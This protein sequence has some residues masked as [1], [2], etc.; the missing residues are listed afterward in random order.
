MKGII[1]CL[2]RLRPA[3]VCLQEVTPRLLEMLLADPQLAELYDSSAALFSSDCHYGALTLVASRLKPRFSSHPLQSEMGRQLVVARWDGG[4]E[5]GGGMVVGNVHLESMDNQPTRQQ[6]LNDCHRLL[7][8]DSDYDSNGF[9]VLLVGDFNFCSLRNFKLPL[10]AKQDAGLD[11]D[12]LAHCLPDFEDV[13]LKLADSVFQRPCTPPS[14]QSPSA[15]CFS[16]PNSA[17]RKPSPRTPSPGV[18]VSPT[19]STPKFSGES[20]DETWTGSE[21]FSYDSELNGLL[22]HK[23][24]RMRYDRIMYRSPR[25]TDST[26]LSWTPCRM[27][28]LG[29]QPLD[30]GLVFTTRSSGLQVLRGL[31]PSDHFGLSLTFALERPISTP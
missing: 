27:R 12:C 11:N 9:P 14:P 25:S 7:V 23:Q 1:A 3:V 21:G 15:R 6:Q 20:G 19:V 29:T 18:T 13:W 10:G 17:F 5:E 26:G 22:G 28:L 4:D 24:Q 16:S 31:W 30:P 8:G 2:K